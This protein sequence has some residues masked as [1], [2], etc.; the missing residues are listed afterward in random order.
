VGCGGRGSEWL[1]VEGER[2]GCAG[3]VVYMAMGGHSDG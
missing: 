1:K 2:D 3:Q